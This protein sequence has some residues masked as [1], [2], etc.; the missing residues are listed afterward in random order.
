MEL[1]RLTCK[2]L[3]P[4]ST[5]QAFCTC[6]FTL[7]TFHRLTMPNRMLPEKAERTSIHSD[8]G[9]HF[10]GRECGGTRWD[11]QQTKAS[12]PS[13]SEVP[14]IPHIA[15]DALQTDWRDRLLP[16]ILSLLH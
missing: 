16:S 11:W 15:E 2:G 9:R 12:R 8:Q 13:R 1:L 4:H 5:L 6:C 14:F 10:K 7:R 3:V